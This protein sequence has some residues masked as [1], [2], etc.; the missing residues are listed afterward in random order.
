MRAAASR[1]CGNGRPMSI[2]LEQFSIYGEDLADPDERP[3]Q[4]THF[5]HN[6]DLCIELEDG[7]RGTARHRGSW[8][9]TV[10]VRLQV[11]DSDHA[12]V[13]VDPGSTPGQDSLATVEQAITHLELVR[14]R[15]LACQAPGRG[16]MSAVR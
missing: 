4:D 11:D 1:I 6:A 10:L 15:L 5:E 16:A 12:V 7:C 9:G 3:S 14:A 8:D 2:D 13:E